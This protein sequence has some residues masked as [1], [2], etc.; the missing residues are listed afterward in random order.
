MRNQ[1]LWTVIIGVLVIASALFMVWAALRPLE[2]APTPVV[3]APSAA[4]P[5]PTRN[6]WQEGDGLLDLDWVMLTMPAGWR[7]VVKQWPDEPPPDTPGVAPLLM[8]WRETETFA[9]STLRFALVAVP[10]NEL[11]LERYLEDV[12]NQLAEDESVSDVTARL[13]TD[14]RQDGLPVALISYRIATQMGRLV[15][16]QA[17]ALDAT[18]E[19]LLIATLVRPEDDG[20]QLLRTFIGAMQFVE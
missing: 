12:R 3:D 20:M 17:A 6:I 14:W 11:S 10:R 8:A 13:A 9:D 16:H 2:T 5:S 18:G 7:Y 1:T 4:T 19:Q 15:G